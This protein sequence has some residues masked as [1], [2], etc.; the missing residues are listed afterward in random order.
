MLPAELRAALAATWR[1]GICCR[2]LRRGRAWTRAALEALDLI[3]MKEIKS[4]EKPR[5]R[6]G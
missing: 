3:G 6:K 5:K 4:S 2:I 1:P